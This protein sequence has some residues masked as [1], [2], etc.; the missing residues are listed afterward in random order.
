MAD[1]TDHRP[2]G[3]NI[4]PEITSVLRAVLIR[5]IPNVRIDKFTQQEKSEIIALTG[6]SS[7][8]MVRWLANNRSVCCL[9]SAVCC[10]LSAVSHVEPFVTRKRHVE[11]F[12][13]RLTRLSKMR[14]LSKEGR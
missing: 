3:P 7:A 11:P 8:K 2:K 1:H 14:Y 10:L 13:D 9:L 6:L 4:P 12:E 5:K